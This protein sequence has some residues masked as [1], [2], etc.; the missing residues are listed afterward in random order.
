MREIQCE[1]CSQMLPRN[2]RFFP[3]GLSKPICTPCIE[4][5]FFRILFELDIDW[6]A[7]REEVKRSV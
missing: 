3:W 5:T 2:R 4:S 6:D 1:K 7:I